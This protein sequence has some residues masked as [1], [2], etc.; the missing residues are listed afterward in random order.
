MGKFDGLILKI[1]LGIFAAVNFVVCIV[2]TDFRVLVPL[3]LLLAALCLGLFFFIA[4]R[5][6]ALAAELGIS[7][8]AAKQLVRDYFVYYKNVEKVSLDEYLARA[9][10]FGAA[11]RSSPCP[12][13]VSSC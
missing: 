11:E 7:R 10:G 2:T 8:Q 6:S 9:P 5:C 4:S 3:N 12:P 1:S 13:S